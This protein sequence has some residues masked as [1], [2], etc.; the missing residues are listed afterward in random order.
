MAITRAEFPLPDVDDPL[1]AEFF[2]GAARGELVIPRCE[3]CERF[4]WY[5]AVECP[6]CGHAEP[7]WVAVSGDATLFSWAVVR[8]AF[9]PAFAEMVPFVTALVA[10]VEDPAVRLCSYIVDA[11][12]SRLAADAPLRV[13][14]RPL[15]FPTVPD[16]AVTVPMFSPSR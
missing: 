1:T 6:F 9:L 11:E 12:P 3:E 5:P 7:R 13:T 4:V 14:F 2:A 8:R 16:R 10:L 15:S